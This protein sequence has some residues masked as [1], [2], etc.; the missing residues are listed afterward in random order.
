MDLDFDEFRVDRLFDRCADGDSEFGGGSFLV[1]AGN[2]ISQDHESLVVDFWG[3]SVGESECRA[4]VVGAD[5]GSH[6]EEFFVLVACFLPVSHVLEHEGFAVNDGGF[7]RV[8]VAGFIE[9]KECADDIAVEVELMGLANEAADLGIGDG[10]VVVVLAEVERTGCAWLC[11]CGFWCVVAGVVPDQLFFGAR[12]DIFRRW[13]FIWQGW[14]GDD[15]GFGFDVF[16]D[17]ACFARAEGCRDGD[18]HEL[19]KADGG[20]DDAG[21]CEGGGGDLIWRGFS[22]GRAL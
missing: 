20:E 16:D 12:F 1:G 15:D 3:D 22:H 21:D 2:D 4:V 14:N 18:C 5:G 9:L 11:G 8:D 19:G 10:R 17:F 6:A 13:G 7:I